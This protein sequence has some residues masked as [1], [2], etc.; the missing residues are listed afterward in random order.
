MGW[1]R[2][3]HY[4]NLRLVRL[5]GTPDP[6]ARGIA[7]GVA[8]SFFPVFGI[9]AVMGIALAFLLRANILAAA[10]GTLLIPPFML[11]LIFSLDFIVGRKILRWLG[12]YGQGREDTFQREA[13]QGWD[14]IRDN[15]HELFLP[16]FVGCV[17]FMLLVWPAVYMAA[18]HVIDVLVHRHKKHKAKKAAH[19]AAKAAGL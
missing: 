15:F 13:A 19:K 4:Y 18:H 5:S 14:Y 2:T 9:H 10:I 1:K 6:V 3:L 16:A 17:I 12:M 8:V 7:C 11:P